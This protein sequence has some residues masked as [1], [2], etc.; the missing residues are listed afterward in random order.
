MNNSDTKT[1]QQVICR[2]NHKAGDQVTNNKSNNI[3]NNNV[4]KYDY[5]KS[6]TQSNNEGGKHVTEGVDED[7]NKTSHIST[8][9]RVQSPQIEE[10]NKSKKTSHR[11]K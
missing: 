9:N 6:S 3:S 11:L 4:V 1:S 8:S 5:S 2:F 7:D 10:Y